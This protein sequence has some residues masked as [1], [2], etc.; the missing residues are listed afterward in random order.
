[1]SVPIRIIDGQITGEA[2]AILP[3]EVVSTFS[4]PLPDLPASKLEKILP[5]ILSD[6]LAGGSQDA[7]ISIMEKKKTGEALIA[8][9]DRK[10]MIEAVNLAAQDEKILKAIWPDYALLDVPET[11]VL[12][13]RHCG[14]I[15][16]RRDNG[17]G[18]TVP[19]NI[20]QH[21][22]SEQAVDQG[23][24]LEQPPEGAGL[25]TGKYSP[26]APIVLYM[27][28][29][30]R[31]VLMMGASFLLWLAYMGIMINE[32]NTERDRYAD[33]SVE[34]FKKSYPQVTRIVN[35]EAQ[36]RALS[37]GQGGGSGPEFLLFSNALFKAV[38]DTSG[39]ALYSLGYENS[40]EVPLLNLVISSVN[41]SQTT[42]FEN[43]LS[44]AGFD[45]VQGDSSQDGEN[46]FSSYIIREGIN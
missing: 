6:Y 33:A 30:K 7:H 24:E 10:W 46:V 31:L 20:L 9:C 4:I 32:N 11:G 21:I 16:V 1:M 36:M 44:A 14:R 25:A 18:F 8:V 22:I 39:V 45:V 28:A 2:I 37:N 41:F 12:Q 35:V 13:V 19:D 27:K 40:S 17:T 43:N 29:A 5:G 34:L 42:S 3:G 15:M 38:N 23:H 26:R